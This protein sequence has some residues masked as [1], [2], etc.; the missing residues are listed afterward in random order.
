MMEIKGTR[1]AFEQ[2]L[3]VKGVHQHLG[4]SAPTVSNWKRYLAEGK[5]VSLD[6]M[7]EMLTKFGAKV[8]QEKVW[9]M[10]YI[11]DKV[12]SIAEQR[13]RLIETWVNAVNPKK[14]PNLDVRFADNYKALVSSYRSPDNGQVL[15]YTCLSDIAMSHLEHGTLLDFISNAGYQ[16]DKR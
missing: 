4:V 2:L 3:E 13:E 5:T 8:K 6:K 16:L 7:E 12:V 11:E 14:H 15:K 1:E 10:P 9:Q